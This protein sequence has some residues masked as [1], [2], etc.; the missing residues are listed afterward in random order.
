MIRF[1]FLLALII[2]II[3]S[4]RWFVQAAVPEVKK[5]LKRVLV[6]GTCLVL[7]ALIISGRLSWLLPVVGGL[8]AI[9]ARSLPYLLRF[10][11]LLQRLW[12][13][14]RNSRPRSEADNISTVETD[15]VRM[16]L[17]HDLGEISGEVLKGRFAGRNFNELNLED[18][19]QLCDEVRGVDP[20]A[21]T[22]IESYLDRIYPND[23]RNTQSSNNHKNQS[24]DGPVQDDMSQN[25]ALEILGL[26]SDSSPSEII[27]AHR[28][29]IQKIH[30]DRGGSDYLASKIN[31]ARDI[32]LG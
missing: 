3:V 28:R 9:L 19:L 23:W 8:I 7:A 10:A 32:L 1:V 11:P 21:L 12:L 5:N 2:A 14:Y 26:N 15:F 22:L 24:G 4:L 27:E 20:D 6:F 18:L 29:L 17:D 16:K 25:E 30:P 31:R 13:Q